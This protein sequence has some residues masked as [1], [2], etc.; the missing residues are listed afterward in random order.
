MQNI[1]SLQIQ[2]SKPYITLYLSYMFSVDIFFFLGGFMVGFLFLKAYSKKPSNSQ[3]GLAIL[4]RYLRF[5]PLFAISM[6][7][8]W[9]ILPYIGSGPLN[10]Q[11]EALA[12]PCA[13]SFWRD[14]LFF[15]NFAN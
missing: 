4:H 3:F 14:M 1:L 11:Y 7:I 12:Q 10:Y 2:M 6:A 13:A 8:Y 15:G 5:A 9:Q